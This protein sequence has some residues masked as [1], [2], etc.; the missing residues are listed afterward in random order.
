MGDAKQRHCE[1]HTE[2]LQYWVIA[3]IYSFSRLFS[4]SSSFAFPYKLMSFTI[5]AKTLLKFCIKTINQHGENW[6]LFEIEFS[7]Y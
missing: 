1:R 5:S 6:Q 7:D 3:D 2:I 4:Y